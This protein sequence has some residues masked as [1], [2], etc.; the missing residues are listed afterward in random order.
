M[1]TVA[2]QIGQTPHVS[3]LL[4]RLRRLGLKTAGDLRRLAVARGCW[5]YRRPDDE[6]A[7]PPAVSPEVVSDAE[8]AIGLLSAS[9]EFD[10]THVRCAA[11]LMSTDRIS[12]QEVVRLA[13]QERAVPLVRHIA[14][15]AVE[16]EAPHREYWTRLLSL[17]SSRTEAPEGRLPH[18]SRFVSETGV[19]FHDGRL[20][21]RG[22]RTWLCPREPLSR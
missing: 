22:A 8:L 7:A 13:V 18:R 5:H 4:R 12:G 1:K 14:R 10:S 9:Q 21:K 16:M 17:L 3:P 19:T 20:D 6:T 15:A 2:E 11:Q